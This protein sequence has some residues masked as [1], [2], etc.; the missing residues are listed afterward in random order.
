MTLFDARG[1]PVST[2]S[3]DSLDRYEKTLAIM[4]C[5]RGDALAAI[6]D[7]L[8]RDPDFVAGH[9]LRAALL[10][11][12]GDKPADAQVE[13]SLAAIKARWRTANDRERR[14]AAAAG[15]WLAR[16]PR[17]AARLYGDLAIDYPRDVLAL[18]L[19]HAFDFHLG[20]REMLRDRIAAVLPRWT[21]RMPGYGFL[22][23]LYAFGLE[24]NGAF[25]R[26]EATAR[27][28]LVHS[29]GNPGAIHVI[30]HVMDMQGRPAAGVAMLRASQA[31]WADGTAFSVHNAWHLAL[32]HIDLDETE[33][34]LAIH[35]ERIAASPPM[36]TSTLVDA[37][38]LLWRLSLHGM[39]LYGRWHALADRWEAAVS[40]QRRVF[41][42]AH[43]M[44]AF[45]AAGRAAAAGG[46]LDLLKSRDVRRANP[47]DDV[48]LALP[49]CEALWAMCRGDYATAVERLTR[50][51]H[52]AH[53]CGGSIAQC[54]LIHLTLVEAA[55][56]ARR[57][58]LAAALTAERTARK[59]G[60][61]LNG[62]LAARALAALPAA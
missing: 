35:D 53:R 48:R 29:P 59:P 46:I 11:L 10:V 34:A 2:G 33:E 1:I 32:F 47:R 58:R 17:R 56:R 7:A 30:A 61:R 25:E 16:N 22:L 23:T 28:A 54:D 21:A 26:A 43:A 45:A 49:V 57:A 9:C 5:H 55:L 42:H 14:H 3:A 38:A 39:N 37:S 36:T 31:D 51:R 18:Q 40:G 24:E 52:L 60:S 8:A 41:H 27:E 62:L 44:M 13:R 19:A 20:R 12:A 50:V 6:D 15:A 4:H